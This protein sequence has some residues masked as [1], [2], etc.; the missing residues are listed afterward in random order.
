[1][2]TPSPTQPAGLPSATAAATGMAGRRSAA[3]RQLG[4]RSGGNGW[5][6]SFVGHGGKLVSDA[7]QPVQHSV[8]RFLTQLHGD[9]RDGGLVS[10]QTRIFL[11]LQREHGPKVRTAPLPIALQVSPGPGSPTRLS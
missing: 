9:S 10:T 3:G 8:Q 6:G 7:A 1:M 4:P 2:A 11:D 5:L